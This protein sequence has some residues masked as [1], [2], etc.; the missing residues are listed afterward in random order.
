LTTSRW[1]PTR[2]PPILRHHGFNATAVYSGNAAVESARE[3]PLDALVCDI[4]L[5]GV[6]GIEVATQVQAIRSDC[7][8][9][10]IS[11]AQASGD[12]LDEGRAKGHEFEVLA[13][14]FH[15]TTLIEKLR[16]ASG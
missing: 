7:K 15:P 11:G 5:G 2:S 1:S 14:P 6:S 16:E 9:I 12:L 3:L 8:I 4:V 13:K 10:L